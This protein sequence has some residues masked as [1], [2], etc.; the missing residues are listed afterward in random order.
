MKGK[1]NS[2]DVRGMF[3]ELTRLHTGMIQEANPT[4]EQA[5][6]ARAHIP[7]TSEAPLTRQLVSPDQFDVET[8]G[9]PIFRSS[10]LDT[11]G[12]TVQNAFVQ[13]IVAEDPADATFRLVA[14]LEGSFNSPWVVLDQAIVN[15]PGGAQTVMFPLLASNSSLATS[16]R[17]T[18]YGLDTR[19]NPQVVRQ[20]GF[21]VS[22]QLVAGLGFS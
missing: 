22:G 8:I 13:V 4:P 16:I 2:W 18:V 6:K 3:G 19:D 9:R 5:L 20:I 14:S 21:V 15:L 11:H 12:Y 17:L 7:I 10:V 1:S